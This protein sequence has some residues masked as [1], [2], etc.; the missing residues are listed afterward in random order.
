VLNAGFHWSCQLKADEWVCRDVQS[1]DD[2]RGVPGGGVPRYDNIVLRGGV[3][4]ATV[5]ACCMRGVPYTCTE[6]YAVDCEVL[7]GTPHASGTDCDSAA[8][9][10]PLSIDHDL[11]GDVD[12]EGFGWFQTCFSGHQVLVS[13]APCR[14]ADLDKDGDVDQLDFTLFHQ[15][16]S[17]PGVQ[18]DE[19]CLN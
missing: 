3:C 8:R 6:E 14:C 17:G 4:D 15:C 5:G 12:S 7:G 10:S 11:D 18:T 9:C 13:T 16:L 1:C 2:A 19:S